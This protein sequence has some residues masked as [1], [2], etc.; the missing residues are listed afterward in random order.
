MNIQEIRIF[1]SWHF[2][3]FLPETCFKLKKNIFGI[4]LSF[5]CEHSFLGAF[6]WNMINHFLNIKEIGFFY[7]LRFYHFFISNL[8]KMKKIRMVSYY[9]QNF[10]KTSWFL[11]ACYRNITILFFEYPWNQIKCE[12]TQIFGDILIKCSENFIYRQNM[13]YL[14]FSDFS[15]FYLKFASI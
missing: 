6:H 15:T 13:I 11:H 4:L 10:T 12:E 8:L 1:D 5:F 7:V 3:N 14:L 9:Y 2:F